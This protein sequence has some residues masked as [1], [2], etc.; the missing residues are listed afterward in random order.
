MTV[1]RYDMTLFI[2]DLWPIWP[3]RQLGLC[4]D[5]HERKVEGYMH[6]HNKI[7]AVNSE[8]HT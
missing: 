3:D 8:K 6:I 2:S 7:K 4:A 1:L 5:I